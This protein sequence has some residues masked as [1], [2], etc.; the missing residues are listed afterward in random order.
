MSAPPLLKWRAVPRAR[1]Y[2]VQLYRS[3]RKIL[4]VWPS[5]PRLRLRWHWQHKG[6]QMRLSTGNYTWLVWPAHGTR[7]TPGYA[8]MLGRSTFRFVRR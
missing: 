6:R 2:N 3:G 8:A 4:S 7:E 5:R 1:F